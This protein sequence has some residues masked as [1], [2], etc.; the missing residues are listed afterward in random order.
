MSEMSLSKKR[1][2]K[3]K[4]LFNVYDVVALDDGRAPPA[5]SFSTVLDNHHDDRGLP[6]LVSLRFCTSCW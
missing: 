4:S 2:K 3:K 6:L 1:K 5:V